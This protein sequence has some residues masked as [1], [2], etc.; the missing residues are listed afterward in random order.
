MHAVSLRA[1]SRAIAPNSYR[2]Q[3]QMSLVPSGAASAAGA[4]VHH[5][6]VAAGR[7][8]GSEPV[9]TIARIARSAHEVLNAA[10]SCVTSGALST[11]SFS[12]SSSVTTA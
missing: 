4:C 1:I 11:L 2:I 10:L 7:E 9:S 8:R 5:A 6:Q 3:R 12:G